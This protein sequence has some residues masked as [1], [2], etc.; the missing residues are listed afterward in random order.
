MERRGCQKTWKDCTPF[1]LLFPFLPLEFLCPHAGFTSLGEGRGRSS[2]SVLR[3]RFLRTRGGPAHR[4]P[5]ELGAGRSGAQ[6]VEPAWRGPR[7][8]KGGWEVAGPAFLL[9]ARAPRPFRPV[10][11]QARWKNRPF[12]PS[13]WKLGVCL[14]SWRAPGHLR[15]R[16]GPVLSCPLLPSDL[17][18]IPPLQD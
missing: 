1:S 8:R 14:D 6:P 5:S 7:Q 9:D 12:G 11:Q 2:L 10:G 16:L 17:D 3:R 18:K 4:S 13:G 15:G